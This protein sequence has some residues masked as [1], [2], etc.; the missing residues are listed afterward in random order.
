[1]SI[2]LHKGA[3]FVSMK[4]SA[5]EYPPPA[6][7]GQGAAAGLCECEQG[8]RVANLQW[9]RTEEVMSWSPPPEPQ[10][11]IPPNER[12]RGVWGCESCWLAGFPLISS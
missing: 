9:A 1:M 4:V 6:Q 5:T 7:Q 3:P 2:C 12:L 11:I 8:N 10:L